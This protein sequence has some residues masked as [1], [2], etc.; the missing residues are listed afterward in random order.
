MISLYNFILTSVS[1]FVGVLFERFAATFDFITH[2]GLSGCCNI[3]S[4]P[5]RFPFR[6][7]GIDGHPFALP[8]LVNFRLEVGWSRKNAGMDDGDCFI[9]TAD[10]W[11]IGHQ[12]LTYLWQS[13]RSAV[14][15]LS[16]S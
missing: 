14:P 8:V 11:D 4:Q 13:D 9:I 16:I 10:R 5:R 3:D 15:R 7:S 2:Y 1:I 6:L 12:G